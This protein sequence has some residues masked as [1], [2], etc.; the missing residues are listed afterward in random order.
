LPPP[1]LKAP[2]DVMDGPRARACACATLAA[3]LNVILSFVMRS[4]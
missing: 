4:S 2:L 3:L 1:I